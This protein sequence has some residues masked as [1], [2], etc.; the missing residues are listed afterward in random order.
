MQLSTFATQ[1]QDDAA[2]AVPPFGAKSIE[3]ARQLG[4]AAR[5]FLL[6]HI[7]AGQTT[8]FLALEALRVTDPAA[9]AAIPESNRSEIYGRALRDSVLFNAWG[10][11]GRYL[12]ET[13]S[14]F[15]GLGPA[16]INVLAPLLSDQRPASLE[17]S[18]EATTSVIYRNRVCD[19]AWVLIC[20][21]QGR[22]CTYFRDP[23]ERDQA[24][25]ALRQ[26][27]QEDR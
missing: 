25:Q 16:A 10:L 27:L 6:E 12:T 18:K 22:A 17:D 15:V 8:A 1:L 14:A 19:Y 24:I 7:N 4:P 11:P 3:M 20:E 13:S 21:I 26:E 9:Y 2:R 23:A 5:E